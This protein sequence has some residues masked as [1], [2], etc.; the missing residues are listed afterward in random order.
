MLT[1]ISKILAVP[2]MLALVIFSFISEW[3]I[4]LIYGID[5]QAGTLPFVILLVAGVVSTLLFWST[6]IIF[7]LG[8]VDIRLK[9]YLAALA[10][11]LSLGYPLGLH[12]GATGI[13]IALCVSIIFIHAVFLRVAIKELR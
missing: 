1:R 2:L 6:P 11:G 8:R 3:M 10:L 9:A 4:T 12:Y 7:S 5:Y 13:S